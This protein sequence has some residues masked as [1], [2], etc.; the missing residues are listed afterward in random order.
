MTKTYLSV[1]EAAQALGVTQATVR[2]W[3]E[4]K[5]IPAVRIGMGSRRHYRIHRD[6]LN[7]VVEN[8]QAA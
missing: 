1:K 3:A 8:Q 7:G 6:A 5:R 4:E 2:N